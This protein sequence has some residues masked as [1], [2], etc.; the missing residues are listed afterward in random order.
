MLGPVSAE[1][2]GVT[3]PHEH[4]IADARRN[5]YFEPAIPAERHMAHVD[6]TLENLGWIRAHALSNLDCLVLPGRD[7][8]ARELKA[9]RDAGGGT[10]VE[11]STRPL[12]GTDPVGLMELSKMTG[13]HIIMGTGHYL[14]LSYSAESAELTEEQLTGDLVRDLTIGVNGTDIRAG[15]IGEIGLTP[16]F[17]NDQRRLLRACARAQAT[18]GAPLTIHPPGGDHRLMEEILHTVAENGGIPEKTV[19]CHVDIMGFSL[20]SLRAIVGWGCYI[21]FD[22][23]GH[24]FPPFILGEGLM[25]FPGESQ[26]LETIR[27]LIAEG[28]VEHILL[29]H[30]TFLKIQLASFGGF[31]YGHILNNI[32][33][34][35]LRMG[36]GAQ[37][38]NTMTVANPR[39]LLAFLK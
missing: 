9:F 26:R 36:I 10:I 34:V 32:V 21:E 28:Y 14:G 17:P 30:D 33:P 12:G 4:I 25:N 37:D 27:R 7:I 8:M 29:S 35:M 3:L 6:V 39:N 22:T 18:T 13:L 16:A 23:F 38:V 1:A 31:G 24:L 20:D 15:I 11:V 5:F 19:I 2:L